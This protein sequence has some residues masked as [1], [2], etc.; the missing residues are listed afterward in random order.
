METLG[1]I[2]R[3]YAI[4]LFWTP[5][6][7]LAPQQSVADKL[8]QAVPDFGGFLL[9]VGSEGQGGIAT[10][11]NINAIAKV[12]RRPPGSGQKNGTA[13]VR[14]FIYG[15]EYC[16][17][18]DESKTNRMAIP[19]MFFKQYDGQ[20]DDNVFIMGKGGGSGVLDYETTEPINPLDG[21][22]K[23][24]HYGPDVEVGKGFPMSWSSR[25]ERW[26]KFDNMRGENGGPLQNRET[27]SGMLGVCIL[28]TN[29]SW[30][31]NPLNMINYYAFGR[32]SWDSNLTTA[33]IHEEFV[34]R[35]FGP[36]LSAAAKQTILSILAD[37]STAA[38]DLG[39]YRGYR[40][41]W[42][43]FC[44]GSHCSGAGLRS[45]PVN[46]QVLTAAGAGMPAPLAQNLLDQYSSGLRAVYTNHSDPRSERSL[47]EWGVF[48]LN[49]TL[50]NGRTLIEDMALRPS[51]GLRTAISM[52]DKWL[53]VEAAVRAAVGGAYYETTL[54]EL[55]EFVVVATEMVEHLHAALALL[56]A[57][58]PAPPP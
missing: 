51:E 17:D 56:H 2:L 34:S 32:L 41:L 35:S 9:K 8:Y 10:P 50:T 28:G 53:Q 57:I 33:A 13:V 49:Y 37:S 55:E 6:Y 20:Y 11:A 38:D 27:T 31:D 24:T 47:L 22:L 54:R 44:E 7:L 58:P 3:A 5:N 26:L 19:A 42:Y 36:T 46:N 52:R 15:S 1:T 48:P 4:R 25:W 45:K 29:P 14:G 23:H 40:G 39:I 30:T 12:L 18:H 43:K 16:K 21:L